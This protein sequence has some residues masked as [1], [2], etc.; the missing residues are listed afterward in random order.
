MYTTDLHEIGKRL[1]TYRKRLGLTQAEVAEAA[2]ISDRTYSSIECGSSRAHMPTMLR[3]CEAMQIPLNDLFM[4]E[5]PT[6]NYEDSI[7]QVL[8]SCSP[9]DLKDIFEL[10][11]LFKH[12][13]G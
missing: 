10:I 5:T 3:I 8:R 12:L 9:N 4:E 13:P 2:N 6:E 11:R 1:A 7:A